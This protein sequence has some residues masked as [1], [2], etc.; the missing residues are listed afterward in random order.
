MKLMVDR[1]RQRNGLGKRL[2]LEVED[3]AR[4]AGIRLLTLDAK[5]G[6]AAE[7]LYRQLGWT[8]VGTIPRFAYDPD[9]RALHDDVIFFKEIAGSGSQSGA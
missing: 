6:G 7:R 4:A 8:Y 2:M 9:G 5:R 1:R 3:A